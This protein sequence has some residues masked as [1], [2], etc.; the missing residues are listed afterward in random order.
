MN[1]MGET[2]M[3]LMR[4]HHIIIAI[5]FL[6]LSSIAGAQTTQPS[7]DQQM[8]SL[9]TPPPGSGQAMP[10]R[11]GGPAVDAT[12]G[13]GAVAP[14]APVLHVVRE[15]THIIKRA[16]RLNHSTD[17]QTATLTFE[18]DGKAM[19]DPP[20]IILPNLTLQ[21]MEAALAS[22]TADVHFRVSGTVTEYKGQNYILLDSA[23]VMA[24]VETKF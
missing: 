20:M 22:K 2:P 23:V 4:N 5:L 9:L 24:D 18:S 6:A 7:A 13:K 3:L 12:T 16:G 11:T 8:N 1:F 21:T 19:T 10:A 15:G 17:G 14:D